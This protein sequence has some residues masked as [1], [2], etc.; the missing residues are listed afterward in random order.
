MGKLPHSPLP[1]P[2]CFSEI[3]V[4]VAPA[5]DLSGADTLLFWLNYAHFFL[6]W[7]NTSVPMLRQLKWL[8]LW[9]TNSGS[10]IHVCWNYAALDKVFLWLWLINMYWEQILYLVYTQYIKEIIIPTDG[11]IYYWWN[12]YP[13]GNVIQWRRQTSNPLLQVRP[14]L[15]RSA[16]DHACLKRWKVSALD[17]AKYCWKKLMKTWISEVIYHV[18]GFMLLKGKLSSNWYIASMQPQSESQQFFR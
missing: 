12:L 2:C 5:Q 11:W 10:V 15:Y 6:K 18:Y 8:L 13:Y 3:K 7:V 16:I 9:H 14:A 4:P 17:I 1:R